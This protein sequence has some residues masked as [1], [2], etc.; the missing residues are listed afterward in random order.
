MNNPKRID[1]FYR[2]RLAGILAE[3]SLG[4]IGFQYADAWLDSGFSISP[5][6]LP[7]RPGVFYAPND[8]FEGLFGVFAD[9]LPD[10]WG[11][12]LLERS[13]RQEG[14]DYS[15][16][17][18]LTKLALINEN[19]L[20]AL[21]Y[22]PHLETTLAPLFTDLD[23][24]AQDSFRLFEGPLA[25]KAI[26]ALR[27]Y[28]GSS[29]GARPKIHYFDGTDY[30]IIKFP[31]SGDPKNI[32]RYEYEA[33][34]LAQECGIATADCHLFPSKLTEGYFG[35]KRF[36]RKGQE[37]IHMISLAGLLEQTIL[38]P[39]LDY[40][41]LFQVLKL[42]DPDSDDLYEAFR[43][44]CFNAFL[45][46]RD[47]HGK[48]FTFLYDEASKSYRLSPAFDLTYSPNKS[49]HEMRVFGAGNPG[50]KDLLGLAAKLNMSRQRS[51]AILA[52][53]KQVLATAKFS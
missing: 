4:K 43:R 24:L 34:R 53:V 52:K 40:A 48:N 18:P 14:V 8:H 5:I 39:N 29:G 30:W 51:K 10:G 41:H 6:S 3:T 1:V 11:Q 32:G 36:D 46:N 27:Y 50:E 38:I 2:D 15:K 37:R 9:S 35:S 17:P 22:R 21:T 13:L 31:F 28:G 7:L 20:G 45:P 23:E 19:G 42:I 12:L 49:E 44:L 26:D 16:L 33:N 25:P 47:D